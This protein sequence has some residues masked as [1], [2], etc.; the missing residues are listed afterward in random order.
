MSAYDPNNPF[1][2]I[3]RGELPCYKIYE[4]EKTLAFMDI[5]PRADGHALV[6][7]KSPSRNVLDIQPDDLAAV[8]ATVQKVARAAVKAFNA[9][10]VTIQQFN[11]SAGG[12][13]VFHTHVHVLPRHSGV[14]LRP[15]TGEMAGPE[16]LKANAAKLIAA[17]GSS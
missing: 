7:P 9:E 10:G 13:V 4:D 12:Q 15:H 3:L 11:E 8:M 1:A 14:A 6:I 2:K 17:L 5:M 16:I